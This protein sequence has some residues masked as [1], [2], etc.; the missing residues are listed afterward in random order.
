MK[1]QGN[2]I[3]I[4]GVWYEVIPEN[5]EHGDNCYGCAFEESNICDTEIT[6]RNFEGRSDL[7]CSTNNGIYKLIDIKKGKKKLLIL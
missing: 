7:F 3:Q 4:R 2:N 5:K 6:T 1:I